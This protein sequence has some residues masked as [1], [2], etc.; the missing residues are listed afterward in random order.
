MRAQARPSASIATFAP[1]RQRAAGAGY[2]RRRGLPSGLQ[3][4]AIEA[5]QTIRL[6]TVHFRPFT[7]HPPAVA[8]TFLVIFLRACRMLCCQS[9]II[10][11]GW[12]GTACGKSLSRLLASAT[13]PGCLRGTAS[14]EGQPTHSFTLPRSLQNRARSPAP[15]SGF[16]GI[17]LQRRPA[18]SP[19]AAS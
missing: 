10:S 6:H 3:T 5:S 4:S 8:H 16:D 7:D 11:K 13:M 12:G 15:L 14:A 9:M 2:T 1:R 17:H 18:H 19:V